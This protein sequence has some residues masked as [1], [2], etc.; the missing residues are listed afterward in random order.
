MDT[1][2]KVFLVDEEGEIVCDE[3]RGGK[4][5]NSGYL[6][7]KYGDGKVKKKLVYTLQDL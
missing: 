5:R 2:S 3:C 7:G 4:V 1:K 6:R